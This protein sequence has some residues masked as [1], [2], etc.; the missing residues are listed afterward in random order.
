MTVYKWDG[1]QMVNKANG[2]P[3]L[4]PAQRRAKPQKPMVMGFGSYN[5]PITGK[6][7]D[8]LGQHNANLKKHN[9]IEYNELKSP[10]SGE[11]K[12]ERF[13]KKRGFE[14][15]ERYKDEPQKPQSEA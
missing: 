3:M 12:N 7:I 8:T 15:S 2:E 14:I 6:P 10:T 9:C 11:Y 1:E 5:C 4:S 13:A